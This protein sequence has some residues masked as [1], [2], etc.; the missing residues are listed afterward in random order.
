VFSKHSKLP[1]SLNLTGHAEYQNS[2][3]LHLRRQSVYWY[4]PLSLTQPDVSVQLWQQTLCRII[5]LILSENLRQ[6]S[7][8]AQTGLAEY[9]MTVAGCQTEPVPR[10]SPP[11]D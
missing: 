1:A 2:E 8:F 9:E 4:D 3:G 10:H 11:T 5:L 6:M 7:F